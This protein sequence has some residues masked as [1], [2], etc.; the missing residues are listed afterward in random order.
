MKKRRVAA[1][2]SI[3][4]AL[5]LVFAFCGEA[6]AQSTCVPASTA[7]GS[8]DTCFGQDGYVQTDVTGA[9]AFQAA[10]VVGVQADGR[11][12]VGGYSRVEGSSGTELFLARY[13]ADG[14]ALDS[15]FGGAGV[16]KTRLTAT[17]TDTERLTDV[18]LQGDGKIV[19][20]AQMPPTSKKDSEAFAV[21]RY[22]A[23][24]SLDTTFGSGGVVSFTFTNRTDGW[25]EALAV[26]PAGQI[27]VAGQSGGV[28]A[29][30][31]LT[32]TGA[33]DAG[34]GSGGKATFSTIVDRRQGPGI[35]SM[36]VD[37]SGRLVLVGGLYQNALVVRLTAAGALDTKGWTTV[38][39]A[40]GSGD[41][42]TSVAIDAAGRIVAGGRAD[43]PVNRAPPLT[44]LGLVRFLPTGALDPSFGAGGKVM[45]DINGTFDV[46]HGLAIQADGRIIVSA[47]ATSS[48][49]TMAETV[50]SR[51]MSDGALDTTFGSGG[52]TFTDF[53]GAYTYPGNLAVQDD[54]GVMKVVV[55]SNVGHSTAIGL[56]RYFE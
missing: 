48:D 38:D 34:F 3:V 33:L 31:R 40:G 11:I 30:A 21:L 35:Q 36:V 26:L 55:V 39:Y 6:G 53:A 28:L 13:L 9:S 18:A 1:W 46:I 32:T 29:V 12:V 14:S 22:N 4:W 24:G 52:F 45:Q 56:S 19:V 25:V 47:E 7:P 41:S 42:F 17:A 27:V 44:D 15:S 5:P 49:F 50:V 20:A 16:V 43:T 51:F 23:D 10:N 8:L 54:G 2:P 37:G